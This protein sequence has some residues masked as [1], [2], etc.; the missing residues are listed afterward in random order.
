MNLQWTEK[1]RDGEKN[2]I[3][4]LSAIII[5]HPAGSGRWYL[6][7]GSRGSGVSITHH[8]WLVVRHTTTT[9]LH[10]PFMIPD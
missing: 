10:F 4:P 6:V 9:Q 1:G 3:L 7:Q 2:K 5:T 8:S